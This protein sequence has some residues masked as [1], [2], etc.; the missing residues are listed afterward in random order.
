MR[1]LLLSLAPVLLP[2]LLTAQEQAV[3]EA[4]EKVVRPGESLLLAWSAPGLGPLRLEPG[5]LRVE[6]KGQITVRPAGTTVYLL[7]RALDDRLLGTVL[8]R[9]D[10][11]LPLGEPARVCSF[12][13]SNQSVL[14]GDPVVLTWQCAGAAKVRLEPGGLELDGQ[15][16]VVVTPTESTRY[17]LSVTNGAGG[18]SRSLDIRVLPTPGDA[19]PAVLAEFRAEPAEVEAGQA[20][21]LR[22]S[23]PA[24]V[25]L[26]LEP[27]GLDLTGRS[28][29]IVFPQ[30]PLV[31]TLSASG[32]AGGASRSV[33]V[34]VR[35]RQTATAAQASSLRP[36][37]E[38]GDLD[39]AKAWSESRP[40]GPWTLR[41]MA[42]AHPAGLAVL[43]RQLGRE[44][45]RLRILPCRLKGGIHGWQ[46]C[47]GGYRNRAEAEAAW[48]RS[49]ALLQ[50]AYRPQVIRRG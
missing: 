5:G 8:V 11:A 22:W 47:L 9:V 23:A 18:Q 2:A 24:G 34:K 45:E 13:A 39:G 15:S 32:L 17:T 38:R 43:A 21:T 35:T 46:A 3:F 37:L 4:S 10:A 7:R 25:Q 19:A 28:E 40:Q 42:A 1:R 44:V 6:E 41:L 49:S 31:Y 30:Q 16:S 48:R 26:R 20:V 27:G 14:P 12:D 50:K 33:E 36:L 29:V